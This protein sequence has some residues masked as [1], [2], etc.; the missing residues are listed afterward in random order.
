[1]RRIGM[2]L[3]AILS[4]AALAT[5]TPASASAEPPVILTLEG[6]I[7][8]LAAEP[9]G[10]EAEFETV[11]ATTLTASSVVCSIGAF[12]NSPIEAEKDANSGLAH[13]D[14][15][16]VK[17]GAVAC[18]S[19]TTGGTKD[20]VETMLV[21]FGLRS[22]ATEAAVGG[23]LLPLLIELVL[24]SEGEEGGLT[25]NC[26]AVKDKIKGKLGCLLLP[27]LKQLAAGAALEIVC[28]R[29]KP[30]KQVVG[31]CLTE[32]EWCAKLANEPLEA[33]FS[34]VFARTALEMRLEVKFNKDIFVDD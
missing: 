22:A 16:G 30:G 4:T 12:K 5:V 9:K 28:K 24:G 21:L 18:R 7:S 25:V 2:A 23:A 29:E 3:L 34:G 17:K 15:T 19:E 27:G 13:C 31:T 10:G 32:L 14:F 33:D 8:E 11:G 1:M 26:G 20:P 6:K